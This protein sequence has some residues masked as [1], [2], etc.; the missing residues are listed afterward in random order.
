ML[1]DFCC[2]ASGRPLFYPVVDDPG[3]CA[4]GSFGISVEVLGARSYVAR[5][6]ICPPFAKVTLEGIPYC[7]SVKFGACFPSG[8]HYGLTSSNC[9]S[10]GYSAYPLAA[11]GLLLSDLGESCAF[12]FAQADIE[13]LFEMFIKA[14]GSPKCA[15]D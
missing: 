14:E 9:V 10:R 2:A 5:A 3:P 7:I 4:G 1:Q 15:G 11:R 6:S 12:E 8:G 13:V